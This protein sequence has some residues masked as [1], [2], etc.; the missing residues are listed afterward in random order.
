MPRSTAQPLRVPQRSA[1]PT[2]HR[3]MS[4]RRRANVYSASAAICSEQS[5]IRFVS[6]ALAED[7]ARPLPEFLSDVP[8]LATGATTHGSRSARELGFEL[9][10]ERPQA[11]ARPPQAP[12][13]HKRTQ[14]R[15]RVLCILMTSG[16]IGA[17]RLCGMRAGK[18]RL[19]GL[20]CMTGSGGSAKSSAAIANPAACAADINVLTLITR[21]LPRWP[22]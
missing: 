16:E 7:A 8:D 3:A 6:Q 2:R 5:R 20:A 12:V 18:A 21:L 17:G 1:Y 13:S 4:W 19:T 9:R 11:A 15:R 10:N 14:K 22:A